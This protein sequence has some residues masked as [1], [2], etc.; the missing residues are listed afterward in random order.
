M[1]KVY[2]KRLAAGTI[3]SGSSSVYTVP[4]NTTTVVRSIQLTAYTAG[5]AE[6]LVNLVAPVIIVGVSS[7]G[8]WTTIST[9][10]RAVLNAGDELQVQVLSG[11]WEYFISGYELDA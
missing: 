11:S 4:A 3:A 5:A 6:C 9:E 2:S 1:A 7:P 10:L 8:Q